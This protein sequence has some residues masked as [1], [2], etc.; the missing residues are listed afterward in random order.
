MEVWTL[1]FSK[2]FT[3]NHWKIG[4]QFVPRV[5][6]AKPLLPIFFFYICLLVDPQK[7][8]NLWFVLMILGMD[9]IAHCKPWQTSSICKTPFSLS[10]QYNQPWTVNH[11]VSGYS[12][13]TFWGHSWNILHGKLRTQIFE[14]WNSIFAAGTKWASQTWSK[15]EWLLNTI[16]LYDVDGF[17]VAKH[18]YYRS[19]W[20][21]C[22]FWHVRTHLGLTQNNKLYR[23]M[24]C[25]TIYHTSVFAFTRSFHNPDFPRHPR[26][27]L[28]SNKALNAAC[29]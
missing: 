13:D 20:Q 21:S 24:C 19:S 6:P 10:F 17:V 15:L 4:K 25:M 16:Q 12:S 8:A 23:C 9:K 7:S 26:R 2:F 29:N 22:W 3:D 27:W 5:R 28:S 18:P 1:L 11:Y 14:T